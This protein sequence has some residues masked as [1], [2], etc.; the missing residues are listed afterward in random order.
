MRIKSPAC[1]SSGDHWKHLPSRD[2]RLGVQLPA[3]Q[4]LSSENSWPKLTTKIFTKFKSF[5]N[6]FNLLCQISSIFCKFEDS[7][8]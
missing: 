2:T 4:D 1:P 6:I 8:L 5:V 3:R 7:N